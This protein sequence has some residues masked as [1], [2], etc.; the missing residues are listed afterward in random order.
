M[1]MSRGILTVMQIS[2]LGSFPTGPTE[3]IAGLR[4]HTTPEG[5]NI[6]AKGFSTYSESS[7]L[8]REEFGIVC[9]CDF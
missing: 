8:A 6:P 5:V 4:I 9:P 7:S 2:L 3:N 1:R